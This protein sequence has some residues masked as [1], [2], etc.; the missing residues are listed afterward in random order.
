M[1]AKGQKCESEPCG[2]GNLS[3]R[4]NG[5]D[6]TTFLNLSD[7]GVLICTPQRPRQWAR[8]RDP[9]R[10]YS[11]TKANFWSTIALCQKKLSFLIHFKESKALAQQGYGCQRGWRRNIGSSCKK[12]TKKKRKYIKNCCKIKEQCLSCCCQ[13]L[14]CCVVCLC[15][16]MTCTKQI[17]VFF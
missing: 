5:N 10:S 8:D 2:V 4:P 9:R 16:N 1:T 6:K 13:V 17:L 11:S 15:C 12:S 7:P 3:R 14:N